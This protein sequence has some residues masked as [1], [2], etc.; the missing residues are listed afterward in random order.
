MDAI[1]VSVPV[2]CCFLSCRRHQKLVNSSPRRIVICLDFLFCKKKS[3]ATSDLIWWSLSA[4]RVS[5]E[6]LSW[7]KS[8]YTKPWEKDREREKCGFHVRKGT[9]DKQLN[10]YSKKRERREERERV[11]IKKVSLAARTGDILASVGLPTTRVSLSR[12]D[13]K[14]RPQTFWTSSHCSEKHPRL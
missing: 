6:E 8:D 4:S 3:F 14:A 2:C 12:L 9:G 7:N 13:T 5:R 10:K 1:D 11:K